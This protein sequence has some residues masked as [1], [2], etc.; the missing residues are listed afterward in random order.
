VSNEE[1]RTPHVISHL[2]SPG[3]NLL[4]ILAALGALIGLYQ[5]FCGFWLLQRRAPVADSP[6]TMEPAIATITAT[7]TTE[8][9]DTLA[10]TSSREIIR[11]S[12]SSESI[13]A[14]N[15]QQGKIAAALLK[16]GMSNPASWSTIGDQ[17]EGTVRVSDMPRNNGK[18]A[19]ALPA[20]DLTTFKTL[21]QA[22][23]HPALRI[24]A[25]NPD[26]AGP[27][28]GWK[29]ALM[30]WGGPALTLACVYILAAHFGWL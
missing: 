10:E 17:S 3:S 1:A 26:S 25:T 5:F 4:T 13:S 28:F 8:G 11:L 6:P 16:A 7:F 23:A 30:I 29:P 19:S 27:S 14:P 22:P 20:L 2:T 9:S 15:T 12:S 24:P 18:T 21:K